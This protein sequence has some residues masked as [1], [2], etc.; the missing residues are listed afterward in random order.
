MGWTKILNTGDA[1][2][3]LTGT[4]Y[5]TLLVDST[6]AVAELAHG[7]A[8]KVLTSGGASADPTWEDPSAGATLDGIGDVA[9]ITEAQGQII[10]RAAAA[11]DALDP[12]TDGYFLKA[13][14][15]AADPV[16]A[17][18]SVAALN[19]VGDVT[20]SAVAEGELIKMNGASTWINQTLAE[21]GI[22]ADTADI[23]NNTHIDWGATGDEVDADDVP[24]SATRFWAGETGADVTADNAPKAHLLGAHTTDTLANLNAK[25]TDVDVDADSATRVPTDDSVGAAQVDDTA[26][27]IAFANIILTPASTNASTTEGAI[28]YDSDDDHLYVYVSA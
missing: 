10:Y 7:T 22:L 24:E 3:E 9:E 17:A 19:D 15:A 20:I 13:Q 28:F 8:N 1:V 21:A 2:T 27:D 14:G 5:R 4:A 12:G 16:W 11:W 25:I 6:G 26:I 18:A 23:I